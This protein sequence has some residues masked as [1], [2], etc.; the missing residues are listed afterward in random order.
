MESSIV[1]HETTNYDQFKKLPYNREVFQTRI[2]ALVCSLHQKNKLKQNPI[3]V[4]SDMNII[5]GQHRLGAA[6]CMGVPIYY[7]IDD[8]FQEEDMII[9]NTTRINWSL[10]D[11]SRYYASKNNENYIFLTKLHRLVSEYYSAF[12]CIY[13][14]VGYLF[15]NSVEDFTKKIRNG[16]M[17]L[18]NKQMCE[19]FVIKTFPLCRDINKKIHIAKKKVSAV[20][21]FNNPYIKT[22]AACYKHMTL[23]QYEELWD[24][25][26][27]DYLSFTD[28][29]S[30]DSIRSLFSASYNKGRRLNLFDFNSLVSENKKNR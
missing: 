25:F 19:D 18:S 11:F 12:S 2:N 3:I 14:V 5:D 6:Q 7:I 8:E 1:I 30:I 23:K 26:E 24:C 21:F 29:N 27:R 20:L 28:T 22:L 9:L 4:D 13:G 16:T 17:K 15:S 10:L